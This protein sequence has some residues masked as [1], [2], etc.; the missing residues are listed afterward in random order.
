MTIMEWLQGESG[1]LLT[2]GLSGS[3]VSV[4]MEWTGVLP[5]IRK[6]VVGSACAMYLSPLAV[7]MLE[8]GLGVVNVPEE[9]G[10]TLGG[11]LM[12]VVGIVIIEI[13]VKGF[14][15]RLVDPLDTRQSRRRRHDED[16]A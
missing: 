16:G 6:I 5:A 13:I 7:P 15:L 14:R 9:N 12:G 8:W 4:A 11:F 10:A 1:K 2:A 3:A